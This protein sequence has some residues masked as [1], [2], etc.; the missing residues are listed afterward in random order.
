ME[1]LQGNSL[2]SYLKQI[3]HFLKQN[4]RAEGQKGMSRGMVPTG[5][6]RICEER[7]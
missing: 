7:M 6:G 1:M 5:E 3:Y 4:Q 2:Y